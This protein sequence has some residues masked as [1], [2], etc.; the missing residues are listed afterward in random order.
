MNPRLTKSFAL[1]LLLISFFAFAGAA[2]SQTGEHYEMDGKP[3]PRSFYEAGLLLTDGNNLLHASRYQDASIKL[4]EAVNTAPEYAEAHHCY[5]IAL[6]R[7]GNLPAAVEQFHLAI[8]LK[9]S[10]DQAWI[11]LG[12]VYQSAGQIDDAIKTYKEFLTRFP[13]DPQ[14]AQVASLVQGL[15]NEVGYSGKTDGKPRFGTSAPAAPSPDDYL[16]DVTRNGTLRWP[17]NHV[18]LRVYMRP[19]IKV[20]GYMPKYDAIAR[21]AF[22]DWSKASRGVVQFQFQSVPANADIEFSWLSDPSKLVNKAE[23]GETKLTNNSAGIVHGIIQILTVPLYPAMPVTANRIRQIS[24]HEIG[25]VL[26]LTGHT[27]NPND[28]M[29]YTNTAADEWRNLSPRD[30][31]TMTRLYS[32]N[33]TASV[34]NG[35]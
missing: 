5:G 28:A 14:A 1:S 6:T 20:T 31:N 4:K 35:P 11:S 2:K 27:S 15:Q 3:V 32:P 8:K 29:F 30:V 9:P 18:H 33:T 21:Q 23:A 12:G 24:L 34:N 19:A 16:A 25:H 13:R 7:T 10:L 17:A 22:V 26:G